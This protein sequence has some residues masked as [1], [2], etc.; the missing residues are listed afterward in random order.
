VIPEDQIY[1][2]IGE[3][4][5]ESLVAAFYE[6]VKTDGLLGPMYPPEDL[7]GAKVR[8]RDFLIQRFGGPGRYTEARGHPRLRMRHFPFAIG[9]AERDRWLELMANAMRQ[10]GLKPEVVDVLWPYMV[11]TANHMVNRD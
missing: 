1:A 4:G 3:A 7:E 8:L 11:S 5:F 6:G 9:L 2:Q 10:T